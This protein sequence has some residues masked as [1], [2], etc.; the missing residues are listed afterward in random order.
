MNMGYLL[1]LTLVI[2]A[3]LMALQR[4][5]PKKRLT[6]FVIL[7]IPAYLLRNFVLFREVVPEGWLALVIALVF[8]FFFWAL[9]GR[10]NPVRSS[11]EIQV[12]GMDD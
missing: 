10:Y 5:E 8:N 6:V 12:L 1:A 11:D 4:A 3:L 2:T 7:L 9:I